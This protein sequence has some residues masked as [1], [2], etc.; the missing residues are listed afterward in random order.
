[1]ANGKVTIQID[2]ETK[3]AIKQ[4]NAVS[5]EFK[6]QLSVVDKYKS[7]LD[8]VTKLYNSMRWGKDSHTG[9]KDQADYE[10]QLKTLK[11]TVETK[12]QSLEQTKKEAKDYIA[13]NKEL[14]RLAE[15]SRK[16]GV[17]RG[18]TA[19]EAK[20]SGFTLKDVDDYKE[21]FEQLKES[22]REATKEVLIAEGA[23]KKYESAYEQDKKVADATYGGDKEKAKSDLDEEQKKLD[24]YQAEIDALAA[25]IKQ[26][27]YDSAKAAIL[28][29]V[30]EKA[31]E[32]ALKLAN[33]VKKVASVTAKVFGAIG[34]NIIKGLTSPFTK[35]TKSV[36][37]FAKRLKQAA[38]QGL[39]F[40]RVRTIL[41][42]AAEEFGALLK[43]NADL[44]KSFASF[45][46]TLIGA[47]QP[48]LSVVAPILVK[49]ISLVQTAIAWLSALLSILFGITRAS[50]KAAKAMYDQAKAT[51]AGG[52]A[53]DKFLA[54]WDTIQKIDGGGG[55]GGADMP[56]FDFDFDSVDIS[57]AD[58]LK[59]LIDG[60]HWFI[61][62]Q[63]V[64][65]KLN[66]LLT[67]IET[68]ITSKFKP[69]VSR[70]GSTMA[71]LL[72][73]MMFQALNFDTS[74]IGSVAAE[75]LNSI[76]AGFNAFVTTFNFG[77]LGEVISKNIMDFFNTFDW[78]TAGSSINTF[79][80]GLLTAVDTV[81]VQTDWSSIGNDIAT[82]LKE[83]DWAT[84]LSSVGTVIVDA[85]TAAIDLTAGVLGID[86]SSL[87]ADLTAIATAIAGV[88][89]GMQGLA[90]AKGLTTLV[91]TL[92]ALPGGSAQ[93][94]LLA[95]RLSTVST[96]I[97]KISGAF[98][99]LAGLY[100]AVSSFIVMIKEGFSWINEILMVV[101]IALAAIGAVILGVPAGIAAAVAGV[102]AAIATV[103]VLIKDNWESIKEFFVGLWES[104]EEI[105]GKVADWFDEN[106][107][108]PLVE[109]FEPII[110]TISQIF[111]GLWLIIQAVWK[112]V[113][114]WFNQH[115][116]IPVKEF[117]APIGEFISGLFTTAVETLK[118]AWNG[119]K[120]WFEVYVIDPLSR[121]FS[122]AWE[123]ISTGFNTIVGAVKQHAIN[124]L[125][126]LIGI[127]ESAINFVV[128]L[129]NGIVRGF[130]SVV[131]WA[132]DVVGKDWN[133]ISELGHVAVPRIGL[134]QGGV[135]NPGHEFAA[136]LG[137]N[138]YEKEVVS[139]LST[140][141]QAFMEALADSG[142]NRGAGN[143]TLQIDGTTFARITNPYL[144][145]EN[146][147]IGTKAMGGL[148]YG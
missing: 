145:R 118:T 104:I 6:K 3:G 9:A 139:P 102:V 90:A 76:F 48:L 40:R 100:T 54:S 114:D 52:G 112:V 13:S 8:E 121:A 47:F 49:I 79:I 89:V 123:T 130:N 136:I 138:R 81:L 62:G 33:A 88:S 31:K 109:F 1:M 128:D 147:R 146:T 14:A 119:I 86:S 42:K 19:I 2:A 133:G 60:D 135:V 20:K 35:L 22:V 91:K 126:G 93:V 84:I 148:T 59:D 132:A 111:E 137:D 73:G 122:T 10:K 46:G 53:A 106:V 120:T 61:V 117:F 56:E 116:I 113:A 11:E 75:F 140:M 72:N 78:E 129:I 80:L 43:T 25:K 115:V 16:E 101:G 24:S 21:K 77:W 108:Q 97:T 27:V 44:S 51:E 50:N 87:V 58:E 32:T 127:I 95:Q 5:A 66:G 94:A 64:E 107:I 18:L 30:L 70:L 71:E 92:E 36:T 57:F 7:R 12:K 103:V 142:Y 45:K 4:L 68:W 144:A 23:V 143:I 105:W 63:V 29:S 28:N 69:T 67:T 37:S 83:I 85:L 131:T 134:A 55:G 99:V 125:N 98:M 74:S 96:V 34:K 65:E 41:S 15:F 110:D 124:I 141:K 82:M 39:V 26:M 17:N 38:I